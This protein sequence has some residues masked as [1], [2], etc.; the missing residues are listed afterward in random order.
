VSHVEVPDKLG[1]QW[2][3][4]TKANG[5]VYIEINFRPNILEQEIKL[6]SA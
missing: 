5:T 1:W 4:F 6:F 2:H 3:S